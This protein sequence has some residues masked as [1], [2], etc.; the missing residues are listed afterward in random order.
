MCQCIPKR[1]VSGKR[2]L[3][4]LTKAIVQLIRRRNALFRRASIA[5]DDALLLKY[6]RLRNRIVDL[7]RDAKASY[8]RDLNMSDAKLFWKTVKFFSKS[9]KSI[10]PL[11]SDDGSTI[12]SDLDKAEALNTFFCSD[13][14][15][16]LIQSLDNNKANGPDS[17][18]VRMLKG[19]ATS[20]CSSL[21][22]L[23]NI[24]VCSMRF[25]DVWKLASVVPVPK[26]DATCGSLSGYRPISL[27]SIV[28]KLLERHIHGII[29]D[30]LSSSYPL[31]Y[32]QW[33][34]LP[35]CS[36]DAALLTV[37]HAWHEFLECGSEVAVLFYDLRKAF[38]SVPHAPLLDRL[39]FIGLDPFVV[40]WIRSYLTCHR[41]SVLV[42][43]C[44]SSTSPV[45]S[46][47]PQGSVL[48][49]LLF[50]IYLD[51]IARIAF[52][53]STLNMYADDMVLFMGV[54]SA[55][56]VSIFLQDNAML[57][58]AVGENYLTL[59]SSKCKFMLVSRKKSS[60]EFPKVK[61]NG[62]E[63]E[64]VFS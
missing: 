40:A 31:A 63:V 42:S 59:N 24:S 37:V 45:L 29:C 53:S 34:F 58:H 20:M 62:V 15:F 61:I 51:R 33:G 25:P 64:T 44:S 56:D 32:N 28:S 52:V 1:A 26:G 7:L 35:G 43:G 46:G 11:R 22:R 23:F 17:I 8:F 3:P 12:S 41:Q 5:C 21:A 36:T 39:V 27:L 60:L 9:Y 16:T 6:R 19:T 54:R 38:D 50:I 4:W 49:P 30:H 57:C 14:L 55:S 18:S 13:E 47:V 2:T 48:G 10:P